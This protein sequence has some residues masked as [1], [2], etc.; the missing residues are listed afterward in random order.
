MST[1]SQLRDLRRRLAESDRLRSTVDHA[2]DV[3]ALDTLLAAVDAL[4]GTESQVDEV[5]RELEAGRLRMT[6]LEREPLWE[7]YAKVR[8]R[9]TAARAR[10][11]AI[12]RGES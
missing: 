3:A 4:E 1:L 6:A 2:A 10:I 8:R 5:E 11:D 9:R 12:L 7:R